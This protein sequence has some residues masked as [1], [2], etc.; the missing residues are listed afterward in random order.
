MGPSTE[1][2]FRVYHDAL[3]H[4][5]TGSVAML[6]AALVP[7][8]LVLDWFMIPRALFRDFVEIRAVVTVVV[9]IQ[10]LAIRVTRPTRFSFLH[11]YFT[12]TVVGAGW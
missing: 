2:R 9:A 3:V 10:F 4:Q 12:T 8:F 5:F 6:A 7:L 11:T 1:R